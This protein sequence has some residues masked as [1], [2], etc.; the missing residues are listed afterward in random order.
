VLLLLLCYTL[1]D[2]NGHQRKEGG[3]E[4]TTQEIE[5][6]LDV[7]EEIIP[8]GNPYLEKVWDR[9]MVCY[10]KKEPT[11]EVL[12]QLVIQIVCLIFILQCKFSI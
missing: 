10:P 1:P 8:I 9:H 11:A 4:F 6:L 7:I 3:V 12:R 5:R 2:K